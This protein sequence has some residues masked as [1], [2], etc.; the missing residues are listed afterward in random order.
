LFLLLFQ[1]PDLFML[2]YL[3]N[4]RLGAV[5]YNFVHIVAFPVVLAGVS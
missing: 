1:W 2:D 5:L 4:V 3:A